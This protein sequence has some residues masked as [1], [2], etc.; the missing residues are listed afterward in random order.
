MSELNELILVCIHAIKHLAMQ[1]NTQE[2]QMPWKTILTIALTI[3]S[4]LME[5]KNSNQDR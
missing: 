5:E 2:A 1:I 4:V 3:I